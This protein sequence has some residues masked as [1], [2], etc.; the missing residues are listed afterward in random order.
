MASWSQFAETAPTLA[1]EVREL[2]YQYGPGFGYLATIRRD[3]GPRLHPVSP[4]I[5]DGGLFCFVL[6]SPK[7]RDLERNGLY[8]LHAYPAENSNDEAYL[9]GQ[10]FPV[11]DRRRIG[12]LARSHRAAGQVDWRLF[13]FD[14]EVAM[15]TRHAGRDR[16][17]SYH[18]WHAVGPAAGGVPE[19]PATRIRPS[20]RGGPARPGGTTAQCA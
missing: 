5:A 1:E 8:A 19:R 4:V 15:V 12:R 11:T 9:T 13:E 18:I 3:G 10:A 20:A 2:L 17:Q 14:I 7:R 16:A 6:K